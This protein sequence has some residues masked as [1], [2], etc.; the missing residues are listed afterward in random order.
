MN[1]TFV[2]RDNSTFETV[3]E[4]V[5]QGGVGFIAIT[6]ENGYLI[7]IL[8]DGDIRRAFLQK[9][10][11]LKSIINR[12]PEVMDISSSQQE[13]VARLKHLHRRHMPLIAA[14][15]ILKDV[16]SLDDI[17]F[18]TR[19]N[20][21]VIMAGG[22]GSRLGELTKETPKP[23]LPV[24]KQP[25]LQHLIELFREQG[26]RKF[27][28]CVNYKKTII[29][30]YFN[31]GS[32]F[33]VKIDYVEE[34]RRMGTAGA[35]SLIE[36]GLEIPFFVI[37]ADILTNLDFVQLLSSHNKNQSK[38]TMCVREFQIQVPYGVVNSDR[39]NSL[40][41]VEEK[42]KFNFNI[43]AGIYLL[44]PIVKRFIPH[45]KFFDMPSLFE[46]L[47]SEG[48]KSSV[49]EVKDYWLDIGRKED[50]EQA[51]SVMSFAGNEFN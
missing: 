28:I 50:L 8:T 19:D 12:T 9:N 5:D 18:V 17:E 32:K 37:N 24:G 35:L 47:L 31:D 43:N 48:L 10:Y 45:N 14:D 15:G 11:E 1:N 25:M 51:N 22:L 36:R 34:K 23:M 38:A 33:G 30:D 2:L 39:E 26:F 40:L 27:T 3:V 4:A 44:D 7:G 29:Q 6:D 41:S 13:I 49:F 20:L 42:P 46:I 21:V 16:F